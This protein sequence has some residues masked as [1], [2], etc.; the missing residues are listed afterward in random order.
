M[1]RWAK[2]RG[3]RMD[4]FTTQ[5]DLSARDVSLS[6]IQ[7]QVERVLSCPSFHNSQRYPKFLR[8]IVEKAVSCSPEELKERVIG[9]E[10][11]DR[12]LNYEP[13]TDPVVR[14]VA[15]EARKRLAQYYLQTEHENEL[16]IEIPLGSYMPVFYWPQH[17]HVVSLSGADAQGSSKNTEPSGTQAT[18]ED[19]QH[20][21]APM[22]LAPTAKRPR[23]FSFLLAAVSFS[24]LLVAL[25]GAGW[26]G[27]YSPDQQLNA[28]W[29]PILSANP[30]T[31]ICIGDWA[32]VNPATSLPR[33]VVGTYDL[34]ALAR[35]ASFLG[36]KGQKFSVLTES[37][38]T[39]T[40]LRTQ[41]GILIG[42]SDNKWTSTVLSSSRYQFLT[43]SETGTNYIADTQA[44]Q[45]RNW[46]IESSQSQPAM[47][48]SKDMGMIS[49]LASSTTG[50]VELVVAGIGANGTIA[51]SEFV[52][53][54]EYFKQFTDQAPRGWEQR[55]I[56]I[57]VSTNVINGRSG[58]PHMVLFD[59]R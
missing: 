38:V 43:R 44:T 18:D 10:V 5:P 40:D 29:K 54:P 50:Q 57:I 58:P 47:P 52:T 4:I 6:D 56:Q 12:P 34:A 25:L 8:F 15:G 17:P 9:V 7:K 23:K 27:R 49:R 14:L 13:A 33:S 30:S 31:M 35:L 19:V 37:S 24:A 36:S 46:A 59:M 51:A 28:F 26:W 3:N 53:S 48:M 45:S 42:A 20:A 32:Y 39:L 16:R 41:P 1:Q 2:G 11:F 55:N 22:L 21:P